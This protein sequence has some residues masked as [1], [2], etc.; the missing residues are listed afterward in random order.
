M[1]N[2]SVSAASN[3]ACMLSVTQYIWL[4][5]ADCRPEA[6]KNPLPSQGQ[7]CRTHVTAHPERPVLGYPAN[8]IPEPRRLLLYR[9]QTCV[10]LPSNTTR[11][12]AMYKRK[13]IC[14]QHYLMYCPASF[15]NGNKETIIVILVH[16][17]ALLRIFP[18]AAFCLAPTTATCTFGCFP[19][20]QQG[21]LPPSS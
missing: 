2:V 17:D 16:N 5:M 12:G 6:Y 9:Q 13:S 3:P 11:A 15:Q 8:C 4:Y 1:S 19:P 7:Y 21:K 14:F 20:S 18:Q 10:I